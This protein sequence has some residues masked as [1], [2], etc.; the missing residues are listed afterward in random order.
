M[1]VSLIV[2]F[3]L[4]YQ[5]MEWG[6]GNAFL[7]LLSLYSTL[8]T[9][10][11]AVSVNRGGLVRCTELSRRGMQMPGAVTLAADAWVLA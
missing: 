3:L 9:R 4:T 11:W 1:L 7:E 8:D 5:E 2:A 10:V 6:P